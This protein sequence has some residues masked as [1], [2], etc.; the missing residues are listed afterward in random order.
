MATGPTTMSQFRDH[1]FPQSS[2]GSVSGGGAD[3]VNVTGTP[4]RLIAFSPNANST[5]KSASKLIQ[6]PDRDDGLVFSP[7]HSSGG[8]FRT[9]SLSADKDPFVTPSS[10]A[11]M[12]TNQQLSANAASFRPFYD[13]LSSDDSGDNQ[14]PVAEGPD[15]HVLPGQISKSLSTDIGMSRCI[16]YSRST[17]PGP[18]EIDEFIGVRNFICLHSLI[19]THMGCSSIHRC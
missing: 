3:A 7:T 9:A 8:G 14:P 10:K 17:K 2:P 12:K 11:K 4:S 18:A 5:T 1:Q 19:E 6:T 16:E 13:S 15:L